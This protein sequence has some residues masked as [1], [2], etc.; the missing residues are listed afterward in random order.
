MPMEEADKAFRFQDYDRAILLLKELQE[1]SRGTSLEVEVLERLGASYW[2]IDAL[3]AAR[4]TFTA[5]LKLQS[6]HRLD[7]LF[8]PPELVEYFENQKAF[9][10]EHGFIRD[11]QNPDPE[12]ET[13]GPQWTVVRTVTHRTAPTLAYAMP[14]GVGQF[15][16]EE[17]SSG[18]LH[19][20]LQ[21]VGLVANAVAWLRIENLKQDGT[22]LIPQ[23][24]EAEA[25]LLRVMWWTGSTIFIA[26]YGWSVA[27]ALLGRL[28]PTEEK[29]TREIIEPEESLP[30]GASN[31]P[32]IQLIPG[33]FGLGISGSF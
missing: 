31:G 9:L 27:D 33:P 10:A 28:P 1:T 18:T 19:A 14:F 32:T 3:D 22:N 7:T 25:A 17:A 21:G 8:Y 30:S 13:K 12:R 16:N 29:R 5:L 11:R 24:N 4:R 20:A 23:K 2:F 15:L 6:D 26:S